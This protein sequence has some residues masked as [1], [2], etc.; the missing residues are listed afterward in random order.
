MSSMRFALDPSGINGGG[1]NSRLF[2]TEA[3]PSTFV[4]DP[5]GKVSATFEG[6]GYGTTDQLAKA[7]GEAEK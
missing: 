3:M 5:A 4:I 1:I 7:V 6:Y 2:H